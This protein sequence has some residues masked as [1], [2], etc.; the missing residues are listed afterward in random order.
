VPVKLPV[1]QDT[2]AS[3]NPARARVMAEPSPGRQDLGPR[4]RHPAP[5]QQPPPHRPQPRL[6]AHRK[7]AST[8]T[9]AL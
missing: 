2:S 8:E 5:R 3:L 9:S 1:R 6:P 4:R 7:G